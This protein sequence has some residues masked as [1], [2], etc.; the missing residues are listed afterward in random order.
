MELLEGMGT[1]VK[2]VPKP[3]RTFKWKPTYMYAYAY[4]R[5]YAYISA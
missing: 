1:E 3:S 4:A 5:A 2:Q